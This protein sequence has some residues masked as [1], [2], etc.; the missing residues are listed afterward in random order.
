MPG[1]ILNLPDRPLASLA[2]LLALAALGV[3][4]W[5]VNASSPEPAPADA[6]AADFSADR[7][8]D[9]VEAIAVEPHPMGTPE[10]D[11]VRDHLVQALTD[12][13]FDVAVETELARD[14]EDGT[15]RFGLVDN[16]VATLPG[17]DSTG[18]VLLTSHYDSVPSGPGA[19]DAASGVAA[20]VETAR[21]L[22]LEGP[23]R[24]DLVVLL[25]D[26]EEMGLFGAEAYARSHPAG[27]APTV[28]HNL[29]ARG[30]S[31]PS[32]MFETSTENAALIDLF[33]SAAPHPHGD[34]SA[35]EAYRQ[36]P[37][38]TDF[39]R[40]HEAGYIG[41]NNAFIGGASWYHSPYDDT[42]HLDPASLQHHGENALG[43]ARAL[44]GMDLADL[45]SDHDQTFFGFFGL[46]VH[47]GE[48][49]NLP[50][51]LLGLAAVAFAAALAR[52]RGLLTLPR[53]GLAALSFAAPI[54]AAAAAAIGLWPALQALR[55]GYG[56][57]YGLLFD[58]TWYFLALLAFGLAA[59]TAWY[60]AVRRRLG[61]AAAALAPLAWLAVLGTAT[62]FAVPGL[63]FVFAVPALAAVGLV[64]A[65]VL[66]P[67]SRRLRLLGYGLFAV[68]LVPA[69]VQLSWTS[70][71]VEAF[72]ME[73]AA[74]PAVL[75]VLF[76]ATALPL[77][78]LARRLD[79]RPGRL[80][81]A[82]AAVAALALVG[83]G[84]A[85][86][87][88]GPDHPRQAYLSYV[89]DTENG[90][91]AWVSTDLNRSEWTSRL[92]TEDGLEDSG[93][94]A[95]YTESAAPGTGHG[96][97]D[98]LD[99]PAPL[100][101]FTA[102]TADSATLQVSSPRG[103]NTMWLAVHGEPVSAEVTLADGTTAEVAI[104]AP[105]EPGDPNRIW[106]YDVPAEGFTL[107]LHG[108]ADAFDVTVFDQ[109]HGIEGIDGYTERPEGLM[110]SRD[111]LSDTVTVAAP[112][113]G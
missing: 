45:E 37:N 12:L 54:L 30:V 31:G 32:L 21:A 88:F 113:T 14:Q 13:G 47:Y 19:A 60:V 8:W 93:L 9:T 26:G 108:D 102:R 81:P 107:T 34:S 77:L 24:N 11:R 16:I 57:T 56:D 43:T 18:T 79:G 96:P 4:N 48:G 5:A 25:T 85:V 98:A 76:A 6:P 22:S 66:E 20:L 67:R 23:H 109:T 52:S 74:V 63:S 53:L 33:A 82:L 106:F 38:D 112:A 7:A 101:V 92:V 90:T 41:L 91:A 36:L 50:V 68:A 62:A 75:I 70:N 87:R 29:E 15:A 69:V 105:A 55:P 51:A 110:R 42:D 44:V 58:R 65:M 78:T 64:A 103:A 97:A 27:E 35:I 10:K 39:T 104:E 80:V 73:L 99:L 17:T 28:V 89:L 86:D 111:R 72:G 3:V 61:P 100:A 71:L 46:L 94:P 95:A 84:L 2:A 1:R 40:F 59:V 49:W 83:T